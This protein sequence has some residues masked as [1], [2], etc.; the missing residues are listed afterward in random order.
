MSEFVQSCQTLFRKFN[1]AG[2]STSLLCFG[3][4]A[5]VEWKSLSDFFT[6]KA[7]GL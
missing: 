5:R 4:H 3:F 6:E 7:L 2:M 1:G